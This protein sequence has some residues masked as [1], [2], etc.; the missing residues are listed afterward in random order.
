MASSID[1]Q[2]ASE[3]LAI[4]KWHEDKAWERKDEFLVG[5]SPERRA[6]LLD[7]EWEF[8]NVT[9]EE[10]PIILEYKKRVTYEIPGVICRINVPFVRMEPMR[11]SCGMFRYFLNHPE[12][13][14]KHPFQ[15]E[16]CLDLTEDRKSKKR[17]TYGELA[18]IIAGWKTIFRGLGYDC[19]T[20]SDHTI[21]C[22]IPG[23]HQEE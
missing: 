19:D 1:T 4:T 12:Q 20:N 22:C 2:Y 3:A 13:V 16:F 5:L 7:D 6:E 23:V 21:W 10:I 11:F 9:P 14:P 17:L 18:E 15:F 8:V